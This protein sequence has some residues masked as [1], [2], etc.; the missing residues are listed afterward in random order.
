M[1]RDLGLEIQSD[2]EPN[3]TLIKVERVH[4]FW[5]MVTK[6]GLEDSPALPLDKQVSE[7]S[8]RNNSMRLGKGRLCIYLVT[9]LKTIFNFLQNQNSI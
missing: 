3:S 1:Q 4:M 5:T 8:W 7:R 9:C 6:V 2:G